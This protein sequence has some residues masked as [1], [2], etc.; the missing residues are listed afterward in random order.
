MK[1]NYCF[2]IDEFDNELRHHLN[3]SENAW[4]TIREDI[5]NFYE[6]EEKESFSGFLNRIFRNFYQKAD[7]SISLRSIEK[8][9][10]LKKLYSSDE[11]SFFDSKTIDTFI[12]KYTQ[13]Y[14]NELQ[15]KA[16][17]YSSG[18]GEKFRINKENVNI[19]K[20][21]PEGGY[22]EGLIRLYLKAIYE[23]YVLKPQYIRE[24]I[25]FSDTFS[26]IQ[27]AI[28][29]EKKIKISLLSKT[30]VNEKKQYTR[31]FYV[32]P[33]KVVCNETN[34]FN[35]L[36]G[37]SEEIKETDTI[38]ESGRKTR[39]STV[40][41]KNPA[42]FRLSRIEKAD[43]MVSMG[44]HISK[45]HI[46]ELEKMLIE[47]TPMFMASEPIKI[48]VEF[49]KKGLEA[50]R[51]Q[52]YMRP[53]SYTVSKDN[54]YL[55]TFFCT[56]VQAINYFFKFGWDARIIEPAELRE[57]FIRRYENSLKSYLGMSKE[58]II[59]SR[60]TINKNNK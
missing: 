26:V 20:D 16:L 23:E 24:Q 6:S 9:E 49:T 3:L 8:K 40:G 17:S 13:V 36:I 14:E 15:E 11:F 51:R 44:A 43:I 52:L 42:C 31:K 7:A 37:Y 29:K 41:P 48:K 25:F 21:S 33:Y 1:N 54:K 19:L 30:T 57:K 53:T 5:K 10:E 46:S 2:Y 28:L 60:N 32:S 55:Y 58:E 34:S 18:K 35:Y 27:N 4:L 47:R 12:E 38:D 59:E 50:F 22:Y 39:T 56:E 45:E